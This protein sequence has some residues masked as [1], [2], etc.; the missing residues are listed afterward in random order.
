MS[1]LPTLRVF[2]SPLFDRDLCIIQYTYWT[3]L[4]LDAYCISCRGMETLQRFLMC[5]LDN[6]SIRG[7][8][9][10]HFCYPT[11]TRSTG[12]LPIPVP[13]PYS[14]LLPNPTRTRGY[15]R[16]CHCQAFHA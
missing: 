2:F 14:K 3:P 4:T 9:V 8:R 15:T 6:V 5:V 1:F 7:L 12:S 11:R 16:T 10:Q 13:D